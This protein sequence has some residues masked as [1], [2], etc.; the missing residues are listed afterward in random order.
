MTNPN[1]KLFRVEVLSDEIQ[2]YSST[3]VSGGGGYVTTIN[4]QTFG[5]TNEVHSTVQHHVDQD[6]WV[7]D[8]ESGRDF[9]INLKD[10]SFPVRP[11]HVLQIVFDDLSKCWERLYNESTEQRE[12]RQGLIN[13]DK[14]KECRRGKNTSYWMSLA[15][16]IPLI[17]LLFGLV[18]LVWLLRIVPTAFCGVEIQKSKSH[19]LFSI[20]SGF[21]LFIFSYAGFDAHFV[22]PQKWSGFQQIVCLMGYFG[23]LY[24][25]IRF[26]TMPWT[27]AADFVEKRS[28]YLD[29]MIK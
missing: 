24:L 9:Q 10:K 19:I 14:A 6:I 3:A 16:S 25:F 11:G 21:G 23:S 17:N 28:N 8:L 22:S 26:S 15:L 29:T 2:K 27:A 5:Q 7:R 13:P 4:G 18:A 20:I 12:Y 1:A